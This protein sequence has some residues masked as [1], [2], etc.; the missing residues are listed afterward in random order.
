MT[1]NKGTTTIPTDEY[2]KLIDEN[3]TL[4]EILESKTIAVKDV[5]HLGGYSRE[6]Y[7]LIPTDK[8]NEFIVN[9]IK[10]LV[11]KLERCIRLNKQHELE[12]LRNEH[13]TGGIMVKQQ[14][15]TH[16]HWWK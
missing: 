16:T 10:Q 15:K 13:Y 14:P 12:Q 11:E 7:F 2:I 9:I 4:K 5:D 1:R 8:E 3:K 6:S